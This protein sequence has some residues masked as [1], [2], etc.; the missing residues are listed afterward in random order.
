MESILGIISKGVKPGIRML[1]DMKD[2]IYDRKWLSNA[3]NSEL[4]Y[5]YRELSLSKKDAHCHERTWPEVRYHCYS[6][7]YAGV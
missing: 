6:A 3:E 5:M 7:A 4:Y 1:F 2:V